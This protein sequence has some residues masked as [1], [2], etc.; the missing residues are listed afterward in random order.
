MIR[1]GITLRYIG[2]ASLIAAASAAAALFVRIVHRP[3]ALA[4]FD[5]LY[6]WK[7][8]SY[9]TTHFPS[10]LDF[11]PD[12]GLGGAFCPWPPL[13]DLGAAAVALLAGART[14]DEV[15]RLI[16]WIPP[17]LSALL[18]GTVAFVLSRHSAL[19]GALGG[20]GLAFAPFLVL[21]SSVGDIDHHFL[22]PFL[23]LAIAGATMQ[24]GW[25]A[26][27]AALVAALM[28]QTALILACGLAFLCLFIARR[29]AS[30]AFAVAALAIV[31]YRLGRDPAYPD[32]IWFLGWTHAALLAIAAAVFF[33][34]SAVLRAALVLIAVVVA[35][36]GLH[37]FGGERWL[38]SIQEFQPLWKTPG[39]IGNYVAALAGG[40]IA[41]VV[42]LRRRDPSFAV[43]LFAIAYIVATIP[44]RRFNAIATA[45]AIVATALVV[46]RLWE[47]R[48]RVP[49]LLFAITVAVVPPIHLSIWFASGLPSPMTGAT[50][51]FRRAAEFLR[52]GGGKSRVL[53]PW[54]YG[55]ML[56]VLGGQRVV[57][58]N[59]GSMPDPDLFARAN[60]ILISSDA[61]EVADY[62]D[63]NDIRYL[64]TQNPRVERG[65]RRVAHFGDVVV[66]ERINA[67]AA[68]P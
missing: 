36:P 1:E 43:A 39:L 22:E 10:V 13:Y 12:R 19:S 57:I 46:A 2:R 17:V 30:A 21:Q 59:F 35:N 62:F 6:H 34:R 3:G 50:A 42:L 48:K 14:A 25:A 40:A 45:L 15:L 49:A 64:V 37:F 38:A 56:N 24:R 44:R 52:A 53:A 33:F 23:V 68:T 32:T 27:A 41:S 16:V 47:E 61:D 5:E 7:R 67:R 18:V 31:A 26:M 8:I 58:D 66:L 65:F 11:D 55:H 54:S 51:D 9:S 28:V 63:G 60:E 4:P 20:V 29:N